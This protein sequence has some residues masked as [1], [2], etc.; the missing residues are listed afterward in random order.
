MNGLMIDTLA[1]KWQEALVQAAALPARFEA[2][3]AWAL[4]ITTEGSASASNADHESSFDP[5]GDRNVSDLQ[6]VLEK[7]ISPEGAAVALLQRVVARASTLQERRGVDWLVAEPPESDPAVAARLQRW[8]AHVAPG[9][10]PC[11]A[12][13]RFR[14]WE[15]L[16]AG[17]AARAVGPVRVREGGGLP[18]WAE[19]LREALFEANY[20]DPLGACDSQSPL[21]FEALHLPFVNI[22]HRRLLAAIP[23]I[24]A[25]LT[26]RA[27]ADLARGLLYVL[28]QMACE[29]LYVEFSRYRI[30]GFAP[31]LAFISREPDALY[32]R[33]VAAMQEDG[34]RTFYASYPVLGRIQAVLTDLAFETAAEFLRRL[35]ADLPE[36]C[37]RWRIAAPVLVAEI[38]DALGDRHRGGG[39]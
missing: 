8:A 26:P 1:H 19:T 27:Q 33:F 4:L 13:V 23:D 11:E 21:L 6:P 28:A 16:D 17:A 20:A 7:C 29:A 3:P 9:D 12:M 35:K 38:A 32:R 2:L 25:L 24:N 39:G 37:H 30:G 18:A 22:F 10:D 14:L 34:L 36:I 5:F 15:A 31:L